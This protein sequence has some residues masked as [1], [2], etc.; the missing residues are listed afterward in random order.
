MAPQ[1]LDPEQREAVEAIASVISS[2]QA[3]PVTHQTALQA[4]RA[5]LLQLHEQELE[6]AEEL[7]TGDF[8]VHL[9]QVTHGVEA[10]T[11]TIFTLANHMSTESVLLGI[12]PE[13][14]FQTFAGLNN[15]K[16]KQD[17]DFAHKV[18]FNGD[19]RMDGEVGRKRL[20]KIVMGNKQVL[21]L[22]LF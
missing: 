14:L 5:A 22:Y 3:L 2:A 8:N 16:A 4:M 9:K 10:R 11:L 6:E 15:P 21:L 7:G 12:D 18:M 20:H 19:M 13:S 1:P 17:L